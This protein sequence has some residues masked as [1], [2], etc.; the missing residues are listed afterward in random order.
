MR[1]GCHACVEG[2][3]LG[4]V[5]RLAGFDP[6][7]EREALE[8]E[9][10]AA[11]VDNL[12]GLSDLLARQE[13]VLAAFAAAD[14][15]ISPSR[16]LRTKLLESGAFDPH[17]FLYSDN[18]MR[19][20][21]LRPGGARRATGNADRPIRFAFVGSLVWYKGIE[22]LVAA[23]RL[24]A[25]A[26]DGAAS[27]RRAV[28]EVHGAF[29]PEGDELHARLAELA[30]DE[31]R[32]HG[33]FDNRRLAEVYAGIDVLVVPSLW[34]ENS[35]VTIHEAHLFETPV[36]TADIGGMAEYVRDGVDGLHFAA[37][38]AVDLARVL[39]RFVHEPGLVGEL[40]R[41]FPRIKT[42]EA[43]AREL[44]FRYRALRCRERPAGRVRLLERAG[45]EDDARAGA[46]ELQGADLLLL[47]ARASAEYDLS[48]CGRGARR[49]TVELFALAAEPA[50]EQ[51]GA[52][53]LEGR[54]VGRLGP[55]SAR[56]QDEHRRFEFDL[57][58]GARA[59]LAVRADRGTCLRIARVTVDSVVEALE[60]V[61][62]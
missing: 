39:L 35:P 5:E 23:M 48:T 27:G 9:L 25:R 59:R 61:G 47:R 49:V 58:L 62:P 54:E 1:G 32:F 29:D 16:F 10:V 31:V 53:L 11:G 12:H 34:Y 44:E 14:L 43:N 21:G 45:A 6:A 36:V 42:M 4:H 46:A 33:R 40:S 19:T 26:L 30:G 20:E 24:V 38:D 60:E 52:V 56:G 7:L 3:G 17:A 2:V 55:F 28:L 50:L 51:A 41:D 8:R 15:R 22:L 18:G 37:G 57:G 13:A